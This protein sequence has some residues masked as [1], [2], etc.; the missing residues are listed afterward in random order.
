MRGIAGAV[1]C[2]MLCAVGAAG[3]G[4]AAADILVNVSKTSQRMSVLIDG[5]ARYNWKVSTGARRYTTPSG[6]F[7]PRWLARKWTSRQ[8]NNAP[9]PH[10][11]FFHEGYAIHGTHHVSRLGRI[12]SHGCVRLAP[13]DAERLYKLVQRNMTETRIVVSNDV[14]DKPGEAPKPKPN[15]LVAEAPASG[16]GGKSSTAFAAIAMAPKHAMPQI[17]RSAENTERHE[18]I[19]PKPARTVRAQRPGF[20]W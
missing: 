13:G 3:S 5:S 20:H 18:R 15:L 12:A 6:V 2:V 16:S 1:A 7:Q 9:M 11:I 19:T 14:I 8:Y 4:P 10:S 17:S